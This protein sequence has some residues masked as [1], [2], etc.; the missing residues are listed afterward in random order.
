MTQHETIDVAVS[1]VGFESGTTNRAD[2]IPWIKLMGAA[3]ANKYRLYEHKSVAFQ[4]F[5][6]C[7]AL[8]SSRFI[9]DSP[10][11]KHQDGQ[12]NMAHS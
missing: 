11:D 8:D 5:T 10:I 6:D 3:M 1:I 4:W 12:N 9:L 7:I 2:E